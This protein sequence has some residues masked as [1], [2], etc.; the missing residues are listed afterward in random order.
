M[1]RRANKF[2]VQIMIATMTL[3]LGFLSG[4][5]LLPPSPIYPITDGFHHSLPQPNTRIVV[6]GNSPV[7]MGTATTWLQKRGLRIVERSSRLRKNLGSMREMRP[8]SPHKR[9]RSR[10]VMGWR[11]TGEARWEPLRA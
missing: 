5:A 6:W 1:L 2:H 3:N 9:G 8:N 10:S 11:P 7:V 4:C